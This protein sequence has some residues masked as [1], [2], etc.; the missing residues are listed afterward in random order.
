MAPDKKQRL[1]KQYL[2]PSCNPLRVS[3]TTRNRWHRTAQLASQS[4]VN[5]DTNK[6]PNTFLMERK[7]NNLDFHN[8]SEDMLLNLNLPG[9]THLDRKHCHLSILTNQQCNNV[10]INSSDTE[11]PNFDH[12]NDLGDSDEKGQLVFTER[13]YSHGTANVILDSS[14]N[15][16]DCSS[17]DYDSN[18]TSDSDFENSSTND[19]IYMSD[20]DSNIQSNNNSKNS[21][22]THSTKFNTDYMQSSTI[23]FP[24]AQLTI[25]DV[26][27]MITVFSV[28]KNLTK[29]DEDDLIDL[30]KVLAGP[31]FVS[32]NTSHYARAK[33]YNP[34]SSKINTNFYCENCNV[35]LITHNNSKKMK[36]TSAICKDCETKY[37][38]TSESSNQFMIVDLDYQLE[39]LLNEKNVQEDLLQ[40]LDEYRKRPNDGI[41][42]DIYDCK[43]YKNLQVHS[44]GTLTYNVN[45]DGAPAFKSSNRSFWPIQLY[46]NELSPEIRTK[47]MIL[48][49]MFLTSKEPSPEL[50]KIYLSKFIDNAEKLMTDGLNI[51]LNGSKKQRNF[52]F[53]CLLICVDSVARPVIQC[54]YQFSGYSGCSW[55]YAPGEYNS[56]A[57]RYPVTL[58]DPLLRTNESHIKDVSEV[59]RLNRHI[60]GV[61]GRSEL[62]RLKLF[63]CV[64]GLPVD[65]MHGVLSG[66]TRQ[67]WSIWTTPK[68]PYYLNPTDRK[69]I[70]NRY[71]KIKRP[72]EIHRI[73]RPIKTMAKWKA[74]E[75]ESWLLF[76]SLPCL[77]DILKKE[78]LDSYCLL[79]SSIFKLLSGNINERDIR[80]CEF[81]L[82]QFV[83]ECQ[84]FYGKSSMTFNMHSLLHIADS[85]RQSG[86]LCS[87]NTF[88]FENEIFYYKRDINGPHGISQQIITSNLKKKF[89]RYNIDNATESIVCRNYCKKIILPK[90]LTNYERTINDVTLIGK[91]ND[92]NKKINSLVS[93]LNIEKIECVK[94][95]NRC[96]YKKMILRSVHYTRAKK[97]DD[98]VIKLISKKIMRIHDFVVINNT[99]FF[100]GR[101]L[102]TASAEF[103]TSHLHHI[104]EISEKQGD[105]ILVNADCLDA[106]L[107][108]FTT[109]IKTYIS[110]LPKHLGI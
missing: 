48:G 96:I 51:T 55:C 65:Y 4:C 104:F 7:D 87:S 72:H 17:Y 59:E 93:Q 38:L 73:V 50:M 86:P 41:I 42:R 110:L 21:C 108:F 49:G 67:L 33:T 5:T 20:S 11:F 62:L 36:E 31:E 88:P 80:Q 35:I 45:T 99:C 98:T 90:L 64:W 1:N 83:G 34:P 37:K 107:I 91:G 79:V 92:P 10:S 75:W 40:N 22:N 97:T 52:K 109:G 77:T 84:Q 24:Q 28:N 9:N 68:T 44:P 6:K 85:V 71:L 105:E 12:L 23:M 63:D 101:E 32:W 66:V 70:N 30:V 19:T 43:L 39:M 3:R 14:S 27:L 78:N 8:S 29:Q 16:D 81:N 13:N 76:D 53:H 94:V 103:C 26:L 54:R 18:C 58:N 61:K 89:I 100:Y 95:F 25:S 106:K 74:S 102:L 47:N 56:S 60:N 57:I 69:E 2:L 46:I 15:S 82:L